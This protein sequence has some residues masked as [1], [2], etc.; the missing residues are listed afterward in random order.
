M[1][2][3]YVYEYVDPRTN[4]PFYVGKGKKGRM[5]YHLTETL[6]NTDNLRKFKYIEVLRS[7]NL[8]PIIRKIHDNLDEETAY[9]LEDE[10]IIKYGRKGIDPNGILTNYCLGQRPPVKYGKDHHNYG[11]PVIVA[12]TEETKK[13]I[14]KSKKGKTSWHKGRKKST[15]T[16]SNMRGRS[17]A[18][19]KSAEHKEKIRAANIGANNPNYGT[20]WITNGVENKKVKNL[21]NLPDGW[22]KGRNVK[23]IK[24]FKGA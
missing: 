1:K 8:E 3:Y 13:K 10:Y 23:H 16:K 15:Q 7:L 5:F 14:S 2:N 18:Y 4:T 17:G 9:T 11:K 21:D 20:Y 22:Y 12:H 6:E 19:K 24:G